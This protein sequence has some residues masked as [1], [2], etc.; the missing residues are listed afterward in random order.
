MK[1]FASICLWKHNA[2][3]VRFE[4]AVALFL[5]EKIALFTL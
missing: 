4:G 3:V 5:L 1:H 2:I